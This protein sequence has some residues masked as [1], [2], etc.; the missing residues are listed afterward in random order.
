MGYDRHPIRAL[1]RFHCQY[2]FAYVQQVSSPFE[3]NN[4]KDHILREI[5][6]RNLY[7]IT[8]S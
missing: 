3:M 6:H 7:E 5:M 4:L 1:G 2:L 8:T